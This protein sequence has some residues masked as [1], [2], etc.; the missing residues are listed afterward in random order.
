MKGLRRTA[1]FMSIIL[2]AGVGVVGCPYL[3]EEATFHEGPW[4]SGQGRLYPHGAVTMGAGYFLRET[5]SRGPFELFNNYFSP[6]CI[7]GRFFHQYEPLLVGAP[8]ECLPLLWPCAGACSLYEPIG[9]IRTFMDLGLR[10]QLLAATIPLRIDPTEPL[11][12]DRARIGWEIDRDHPESAP[13]ISAWVDFDKFTLLLP[14]EEQSD[15]TRIYFPRFSLNIRLRP[16]G[17]LRKTFQVSRIRAEP[18]QAWSN[19]IPPCRPRAIAE[20]TKKCEWEVFVPPPCPHSNGL[21]GLAPVRTFCNWTDEHNQARRTWCLDC[22]EQQFFEDYMGKYHDFMCISV[23]SDIP[24]WA[25]LFF[26]AEKIWDLITN[27]DGKT[28]GLAERLRQM[29]EP[30]LSP[31]AEQMMFDPFTLYLL[32]NGR[33]PTNE[34]VLSVD[35]DPPSPG[36]EVVFAL[37]PDTDGDHIRDDRDNCPNV[38]NWL[39][40]DM[41]GDGIGDACDPT[42]F[43]HNIRWE[44][45]STGVWLE[46]G[47]HRIEFL[48]REN[49][50]RTFARLEVGEGSPELGGKPLPPER[51]ASGISR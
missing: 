3:D 45:T 18:F 31:V 7:E 41:D 11:R 38:P 20:C 15:L 2:L 40:T 28:V 8:P 46:P 5:E 32:S 26:N 4:V 24:D 23:D 48:V 25:G 27:G 6:R 50:G 16:T 33:F 9:V 19:P 37:A 44:S 13:E 10:A 49:T 43:V 30:V 51:C 47:W 36:N 22:S 35:Q 17:L 39:Q 21:N 1:L 42:L 34:M 14:P 12:I 29:L